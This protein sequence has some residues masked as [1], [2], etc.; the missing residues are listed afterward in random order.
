MSSGSLVSIEA[1]QG[2]LGAILVNPEALARVENAITADDFGE[3]VHRELFARMIET[4][5]RGS[6]MHIQLA[7]AVLGNF[8]AEDLCGMT[9][10]AYVARLAAEATTIVNAPDF[11]RVIRDLADKRRILSTAEGLQSIVKSD[12]PPAEFAAAAIEELDGIVASRTEQGAKAVMIGDAAFASIERMQFALDNPGRMTGLRTGLASLDERTGGL[13]RGEFVVLAGRPGMGKSALA[14]T[15]AR[16]MGGSGFNVLFN[17]L[18]MTKEALADRALAD[19]IYRSD[20]PLHYSEI[21][22]GRVTRR[23]QEALT[24]AARSFRTFPI[25]I[26]PQAS[27]TVSQI[28]SRAR[29]HKRALERQGKTLDVLIID[30]MHITRASDRYAGN[31]VREVTEISGA[32]KA[33]A[34]EL[35]IPVVALAQLSRKVEE[36]ENKRPTLSDL[37]ESGAIE[38]DA[39]L[40]AFVYREAYYLANTKCDAPEQDA[41]RIARLCEVENVVEVNIAKQ[42]NGPVGAIELFCDIACNAF[43]DLEWRQ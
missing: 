13:Q 42:R 18:E 6:V 41:Q 17:A 4:R 30:H 11:A 2:L 36:R 16:L 31:A 1:E 14:V 34:K 27:L 12:A 20:E 37:R 5:D 40:I 26:D 3:A 9:V 25:K 19:M 10:S 28:A 8:G 29:K 35:N 24:E 32:L 15:I 43:R 38:Q 33:L 21:S 22:R 7:S 39:D 23:Q